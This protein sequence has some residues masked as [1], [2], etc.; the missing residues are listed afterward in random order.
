LVR[1]DTRRKPQIGSGDGAPSGGSV[2]KHPTNSPS[3]VLD[4]L[5]NGAC[6]GRTVTDII[7]DYF[8][9]NKRS[10]SEEFPAFPPPPI[11]RTLA[12]AEE[13][14]KLL[15]RGDV[16]RA[17]LAHVYGFTRARVTQILNLLKLHS[18]ILARL[19]SLTPGPAASRL[20]ERKV[21]P[22]LLLA[23]PHQLE[24][25]PR[26]IPGFRRGRRFRAAY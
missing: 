13:F 19:R 12:L 2:N 8:E 6:S 17:G 23:G 25:A 24:V 18:D 21:R 4:W 7:I 26:V 14:K 10:R 16:N 3:I 1:I 5:P 11:L 9:V 15:D 22:L 20:T